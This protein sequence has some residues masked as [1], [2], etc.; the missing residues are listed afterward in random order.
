MDCLYCYL[1][2]SFIFGYLCGVFTQDAVKF[3]SKI[4]L[5][6][7]GL[8]FL[9]LA[10]LSDVNDTKKDGPPEIVSVMYDDKD[11][12]PVDGIDELNLEYDKEGT[13]TGM[14]VDHF[15]EKL[16]LSDD[17]SIWVFY[18]YNGTE[19]SRIMMVKELTSLIEPYGI[20]KCVED[21]KRVK[22]I[23]VT[24]NMRRVE[25]DDETVSNDNETDSKAGSD[26]DSD[27]EEETEWDIKQEFINVLGPGQNYH[28]SPPTL[29]EFVDMLRNNF[30]YLD[31]P[32]GDDLSWDLVIT[33]ID[34]QIIISNAQDELIWK[35]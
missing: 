23:D 10:K 11:G 35:D 14:D 33:K 6:S 19:Y 28:L 27:T 31:L 22:V 17:D 30:G 20:T 4:L 32:E 34:K 5:D 25:S 1:N 15:K 21:P 9:G 26:N 29:K 7:V 12:N 13:L 8:F 16:S 2:T 18:D 24:L 3:A